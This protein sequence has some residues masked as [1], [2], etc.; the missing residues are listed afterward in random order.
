[1]LQ[2]KKKE[3]IMALVEM[4]KRHSREQNERWVGKKQEILLE[5]FD[6]D[7][8][9]GRN[10]ANVLTYAPKV[11]GVNIGDLVQVNIN[12]ASPHGLKGESI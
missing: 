7:Q 2:Q 6:Q 11:E 3:R 1:M 4:Q 8:M 5:R 12:S 9:V 10:D